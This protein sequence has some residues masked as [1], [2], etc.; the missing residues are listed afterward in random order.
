M[1][2]LP[3]CLMFSVAGGAS[4]VRT[5]DAVNTARAASAQAEESILRVYDLTRIDWHALHFDHLANPMRTKLWPG[6]EMS[7]GDVDVFRE[8][9]EVSNV[10]RVLA[11]IYTLFEDEFQYEGRRLEENGQ[12][13]LIVQGPAA[14]HERIELLLTY[15]ESVLHARARLAVDVWSLPAGVRAER[16]GS[17]VTQQVLTEW[18]DKLQGMGATRT[19]YD[20]QLGSDKTSFIKLTRDL[21]A[22]VDYDVE[23]AHAATVG[24]PIFEI[25]SVGT[26]LVAKAAPSGEGLH[27][28]L[29]W[30]HSEPLQLRRDREIQSGF[31]ISSPQDEPAVFEENSHLTDVSLMSRSMGFSTHLPSDHALVIGARAALDRASVGEFVVLRQVGGSLPVS[32]SLQLDEEGRELF[33][34]HMGSVVPPTVGHWGELMRPWGMRSSLALQYTRRNRGTGM[35]VQLQPREYGPFV[36]ILDDLASGALDLQF[37]EPWLLVQPAGSGSAA[38]SRAVRNGFEELRASTELL[39]ISLSLE[40][41]GNEVIAASLPARVGSSCSLVLGIEEF[42]QPDFDVEVAQF[43]ATADPQIYTSLD[44]LVLYLNPLVGRDGLSMRVRGAG[45]LLLDRK[46][47]GLGSSIPTSV[48]QSEYAHLFVN[49]TVRFEPSGDS[50]WSHTFGKQSGATGPADLTLRIEVRR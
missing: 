9:D 8:R 18:E 35:A 4:A 31:L 22:I 40:Q 50:Q 45:H 19:S 3:L 26:R 10:D 48:D 25:I 17:V 16:P 46:T 30:K 44:G 32:A 2:L 12:G 34:G 15:L 43:A 24:D 5:G 21:S 29:S 39:D 1:T 6:F 27:L 41:G 23:I 37:Q 36:G 13:Q 42:E 11:L 33:F 47:V 28:A 7:G 38:T 20:L 49:E 14:L